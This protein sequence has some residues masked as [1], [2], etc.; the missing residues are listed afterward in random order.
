LAGETIDHDTR[1]EAS[2]VA[3]L[4]TLDND[5]TQDEIAAIVDVVDV[6][7]CIAVVL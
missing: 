6:G 3:V 2:V 5:Q 4:E 1:V 7:G